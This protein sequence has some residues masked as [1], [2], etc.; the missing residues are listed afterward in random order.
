[1]P[2][3]Q[4]LLPHPCDSCIGKAARKWCIGVDG[5][6]IDGTRGRHHGDSA[7]LHYKDSLILL[8]RFACL[9]VLV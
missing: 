3:L 1:M 4:P 9:H 7:N 8:N 5:C 6:T 2:I